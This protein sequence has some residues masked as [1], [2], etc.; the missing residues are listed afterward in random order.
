MPP[1]SEI[2]RTAHPDPIPPPKTRAFAEPVAS[3]FHPAHAPLSRKALPAAPTS[4]NTPSPPNDAGPKKAPW[5][6]K[7]PYRQKLF[8]TSVKVSVVV[9]R[10]IR[11]RVTL[12]TFPPKKY[13]LLR[14]PLLHPLDKLPPNQLPQ[15][16]PPCPRLPLRRF[17]Y[18]IGQENRRSMHVAF[19]IYGCIVSMVLYLLR[20]VV[21]SPKSPSYP[22]AHQ[23]LIRPTTP[24]KPL[25][26]IC[27]QV[28]FSILGS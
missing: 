17:T 16:Y 11:R 23:L 8:S 5:P 4:A 26:I 18:Q 28:G 14:L 9:F 10:Q 12:P 24:Y 6:K 13:R 1:T 20:F 3:S 21:H 25:I 7:P 19:I 15:R 22:I 2:Q 27:L